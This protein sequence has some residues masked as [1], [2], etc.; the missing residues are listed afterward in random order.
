MFAIF[1]LKPMASR[2]AKRNGNLQR[3]C[4]KSKKQ[5]LYTVCTKSASKTYS[6]N[7]YGKKFL[8]NFSRHIFL[9]PIPF[10]Q[11]KNTSG[12]STVLSPK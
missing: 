12:C 2:Q 3:A 4:I 10:K 5:I 1:T 11:Y 7:I 9:A 8:E 6:D